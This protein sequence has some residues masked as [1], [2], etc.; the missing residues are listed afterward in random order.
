[1]AKKSG[2]QDR[3]PAAD[4]SNR[5]SPS[6]FMRGLRPEHYSD[7]TDRV[8]YTLDA[9]VF[10]YHLSSITQRN[11]THDFEVFCRKLCE[12]TI[13]PHLRAQSGPE[14]GG[15]SKADTESFPVAEEIAAITYV[16][17]PNAG[18]ERWAFAFSAKEKWADK[19]RL[20]VKGIA[21]T[22]RSYNRIIFVTNQAARSKDRA[23]IE[24]ELTRVYGVPVTIHDR[25]WIMDQV[26]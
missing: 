24:D 16:G 19:V 15:D 18:N 2:K 1:M 17:E 22:K 23:R 6:Q 21:E 10:E 11:Q 14:G 12:R 5:I 3:G 25:A 8:A 20:D 7:T 13:C 26:I 4:K 9:S